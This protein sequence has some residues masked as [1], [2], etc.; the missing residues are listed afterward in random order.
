[1]GKRTPSSKGCKV[2]R[3]T[4]SHDQTTEEGY[5]WLVGQIRRIPENIPILFWGS[6]PCTRGTPWARYNLRRYPDTFPKRL[7][8]LRAEWRTLTYNLKRLSEIIQRRHGH[9]ALE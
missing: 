9:W 7:R 2:I 4:T 1:M 8:K 6:I 5:N 3:V